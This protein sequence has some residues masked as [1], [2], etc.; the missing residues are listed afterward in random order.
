MHS[1]ASRIVLAEVL[2]VYAQMSVWFCGRQDDYGDWCRRDVVERHC[3]DPA[4]WNSSLVPAPCALPFLATQRGPPRQGR[5]GPRSCTAP[6]RR[7]VQHDVLEAFVRTAGRREIP[8]GLGDDGQSVA[9]G[10]GVRVIEHDNA[11]RRYGGVVH[12]E[13]A[14]GV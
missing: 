11:S 13:H 5:R 10:T 6:L 7:L 4:D 9:I 14:I 12:N 8:I 2:K 1:S 3:S